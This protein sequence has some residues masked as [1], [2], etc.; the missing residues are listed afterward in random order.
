MKEDCMLYAHYNNAYNCYTALYVQAFL[1]DTGKCLRRNT[2]K[3]RLTLGE[4]TDDTKSSR[5]CQQCANKKQLISLQLTLPQK[6]HNL[7][8]REH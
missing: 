2:S 7:D 1:D 3:A 4:E 8:G 5:Q 6:T